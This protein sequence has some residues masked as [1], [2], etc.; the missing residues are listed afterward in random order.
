MTCRNC[1]I[2]PKKL[3]P[4]PIYP[5]LTG[6]AV[7]ILVILAFMTF[8]GCSGDTSATDAGGVDGGVDAQGKDVGKNEGEDAVEAGSDGGGEG[9]RGKDGPDPSD[10]SGSPESGG[11]DSSG[12]AKFALGNVCAHPYECASGFCTDGVCCSVR[13]CTSFCFTCAAGTNKAEPGTCTGY[14]CVSCFCNASSM[15]CHC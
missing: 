14:R 11:S 15:M 13:E 9:A 3:P 5:F 7:L 1:G 8:V 12:D 2:D 10:A 6:V 4:D